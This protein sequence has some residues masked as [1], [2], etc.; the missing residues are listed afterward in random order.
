MTTPLLLA[1]A[2]YTPDPE[3][4]GGGAPWGQITIDVRDATRID[5]GSGEW[6][7]GIALASGCDLDHDPRAGRLLGTAI[8]G[9]RET[10]SDPLTLLLGSPDENTVYMLP[11]D[12][13]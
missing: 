3:P 10:P 5:G 12:P 4:P 9:Y 13:E 8:A 2:A 7:W 6:D 1:L 11:F